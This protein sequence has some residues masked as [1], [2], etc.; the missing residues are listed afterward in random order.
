MWEQPVPWVGLFSVQGLWAVQFHEPSGC[1][2]RHLGSL[3]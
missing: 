2:D 3:V 1:F